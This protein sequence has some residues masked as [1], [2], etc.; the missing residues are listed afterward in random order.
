VCA[1][2]KSVI[3]NPRAS[4]PPQRG[5]DIKNQREFIQKRPKWVLHIA[6]VDDHLQ[7][8]LATKSYVLR[9]GEGVE[10]GAV[11]TD[12]YVRFRV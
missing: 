5:P 7:H 6:R 3:A 9:Q 11:R 2:I 1:A 12:L 4:L 8:H 10:K